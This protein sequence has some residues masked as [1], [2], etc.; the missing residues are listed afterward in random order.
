M[1]NKLT[2]SLNLM[3]ADGFHYFCIG[4]DKGTKSDPVSF[5]CSC[6]CHTWN[7]GTRPAKS[8]AEYSNR[9][10]TEWQFAEWD[11]ILKEYE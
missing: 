3:C 1:A 8:Q 4:G 5:R 7:G 11:E 2:I 6:P 10:Q 9:I